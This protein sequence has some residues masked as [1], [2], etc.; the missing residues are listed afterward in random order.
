MTVV[1]FH[2]TLIDVVAI[3]TITDIPIFT[4][5]SKTT[6]MILTFG[7]EITIRLAIY[8][9]IDVSTTETVTREASVTFATESIIR[10]STS[11]F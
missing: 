5:T 11:S 4:F 7:I 6:G 9:F 10:I 3:P 8:A 2:L 1:Q